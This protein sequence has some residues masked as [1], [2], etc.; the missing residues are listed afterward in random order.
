M[1]L[2]LKK[3]EKQMKERTLL[4]LFALGLLLVMQIGCDFTKQSMDLEKEIAEAI[5]ERTEELAGNRQLEEIHYI[6]IVEDGA[7]VFYQEEKT[8]HYGFLRNYVEDWKWV[9]GGGGVELIGKDNQMKAESEQA[10][11]HSKVHYEDYPVHQMIYG[12]VNDP[13]IVK[14]EKEVDEGYQQANISRLDNG[15]T[16]WYMFIEDEDRELGRTIGKS[17][18]GE[19]IYER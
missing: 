16:L 2:L 17:R 6:T 19:V 5:Q 15:L 18:D 10:M 12:V 8:L 4:L 13:G 7:F 1:I 14:I 9:F 3:E 11:T